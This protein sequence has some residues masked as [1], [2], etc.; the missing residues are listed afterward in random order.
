MRFLDKIKKKDRLN[1]DVPHCVQD[2][3]PVQRIYKDGIFYLG[4]NEYSMS[5]KFSDINFAVSNKDDKEGI[6]LKYCE[7][8]NTFDP[9]A[10][11]QITLINRKLSRSDF[12]RLKLNNKCSDNLERHRIAYNKI[13]LDKALYSNRMM[14][15]KYITVAVEK[16]SVE[17]ARVYFTRTS[18]ELA[19]HLSG[20]NSQL[21]E[22][23]CNKRLKILYD[24][25]RGY[26]DEN[27]FFDI[28]DSI[29]K[30]H[31]F[32]DYICPDGAEIKNSYIKYGNK[33][34]RVLFIREYANF[35]KDSFIAELTD[36]NKNMMLT[37][38]ALSVP[39][40]E[41]VREA[42][43]RRLGVE[44]NIANYQR[45]QNANLNFSS[46]LTYDLQQQ[47]IESKEFLDDLI[48]R[49]QRMFL[50]T[51]TIV[52]TADSLEELNN[53]TETINTIGQRNLC[54]IGTLRYQQLEA[55]NTTLPIGLRKT[56]SLRT[57]TT[58]S[59]GAFVPFKVQEINDENGIYYGQN[60]ISK[61]MIIA[62]RRKLLNGNSFILGVSGS[63][64][65]FTAKQ[66]IVS[67]LLREPDADI[68]VIDP[69]REYRAL[70]QAFGGEVIDISAISD[71]HINAMDL[72]AEYGVDE[73]GIQRSPIILK[74]EFIM[75]LCELSVGKELSTQHYAVVD[76]CANIVY[77]NYIQNNYQ[78]EVPTLKTFREELLKQPEEQAK[79][80]ALALEL[81][82]EGSLNT[83]AKP[84]NVD[85]NNRFVCFDILELG[86]QLKSVG[87]LVVLDNILNRITSNRRRGKTTYVFIDEIYLLFK[88][89]YSSG[90]LSTLWKRVRK[91]GGLCTGITQNIVE[92]MKSDAAQS[93]FSNSEFIIMLNQSSSDREVIKK[94][95]GLTDQE[96]SYITN[97]RSGQGLL[98]INNNII[99]FINEFP[100]DTE[101]YRLMSTKPK[102]FAS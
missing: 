15:D 34:V 64:K 3:I 84:T 32:K 75:S 20:L 24:F 68:I 95:F 9:S 40:D 85:V 82:T 101:L 46:E 90:F 41:A 78:G 13:L 22:Q 37:I 66:E 36:L 42:E 61:N 89:G 74:S 52:H 65:S 50:C 87:M 27:F 54:Q 21:E 91:Y 92:I 97:V 16:K 48:T 35:I 55:L 62:D 4:K 39:M 57:L 33:Y 77:R 53:D 69:E 44:T 99:P 86:A 1:F 14:Q 80:I 5:Y 17:D 88:S 67:A 8:L 79:D 56:Q 47:R 71:T 43:N 58:E 29:R 12:E 73:D 30:G 98:K 18:L 25:Y 83:F 100:K 63:G 10:L 72:N 70:T 102:E 96:L 2:C 59:L 60:V 28:N 38:S 49:D 7:L 19:T 45:R 93:M 51:I 76:R 23:D 11:S 6:F 94:Q 26:K 81:F 31:D